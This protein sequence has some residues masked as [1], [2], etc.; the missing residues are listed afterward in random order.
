MFLIEAYCGEACISFIDQSV[1][2][3]EPIDSYHFVNDCLAITAALSGSDISFNF[4]KK[5]T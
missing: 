5:C 4:F 1:P 2:S 3:S